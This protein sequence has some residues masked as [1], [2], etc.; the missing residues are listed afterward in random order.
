VAPLLHIIQALG[1]VV[2]SDREVRQRV[3]VVL[4]DLDLLLLVMS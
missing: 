4:V 1:F 2:F 3:V